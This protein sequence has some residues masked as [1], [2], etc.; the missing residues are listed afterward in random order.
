M[1]NNVFAGCTNI[2]T[3]GIHQGCAV[4][5]GGAF[6]GC[7][8]L[9]SL[10]IPNSVLSMGNSAFANCT[11]LTKVTIGNGLKI[12]P[13][14]AFSGCVNLET[15]ELGTKVEEIGYR[16]FEGCTNLSSINLNDN[17]TT[18]GGYAF[19]NCTSLTS[20]VLGESILSMDNNVFAGCTNIR[21]VDIHQ[22]CAVIGGGTFG[23][24]TKLQTIDVPNSVLKIG[25]SAFSNCVSLTTAKIGNG[26]ET[27]NQYLF[28]NCTRLQTVSL[29]SGVQEVAYRAFDE[30][31]QLKSL[32]ILNPQTPTMGD[33]AFA[34]Y[35]ATLYVPSQSTSAYM[36]HDRWKNFTKI[37]AVEGQVYLTI[38]QAE[39]G[40][41]RQAVKLGEP[42]RFDLLP[43]EGYVIHSV[44]FNNEDVTKQLVDNTFTTPSLTANSV[45]SVVFAL[46]SSIEQVAANKTKVS[47]DGNGTIR[48]NDAA[49]GETITVYS[50]NGTIVKQMP[51]SSKQT[52]VSISTPGIY[53]VKVGKLTTKLSL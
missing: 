23:N 4:I 18:F 6:S 10:A 45:L 12:I 31:K 42:Y 8:K 50:T 29:G 25:N 14:Y 40:T 7:K 16:S 41:V 9:Q 21:T 36:A 52:S 13:Q 22:G 37:E 39:Q 44:T 53:I 51:A 15:V 48:V 46:A 35:N 20:V 11:S 28:S 24:C 26:V 5:G 17:I 30:C 27:I 32:T 49:E 38:R 34:N 33:Y 47:V 3:V 1:D 2:R 19:E 43:T